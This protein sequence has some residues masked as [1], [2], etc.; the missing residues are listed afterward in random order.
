MIPLNKNE[1]FIEEFELSGNIQDII[2]RN[3]KRI[4]M[5][6]DDYFDEYLK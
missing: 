1:N 3:N 5:L 4:Q 2:R 6:N